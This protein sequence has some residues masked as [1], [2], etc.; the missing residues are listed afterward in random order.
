MWARLKISQHVY[1]CVQYCKTRLDLGTIVVKFFSVNMRKKNRL[2]MVFIPWSEIHF[3]RC[4]NYEQKIHTSHFSG[5]SHTEKY[6]I[7]SN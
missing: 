2:I 4:S 3:T 7:T 1:Y 5:I 6:D